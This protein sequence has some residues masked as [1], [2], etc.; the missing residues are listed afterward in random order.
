VTWDALA[1][2][3]LPSLGELVRHGVLPQGTL[4]TAVDPEGQFI[5]EIAGDGQ[6]TVGEF[7]YSSP[8]RAARE[9]GSDAGDGWTY[10]LA[11]INT[12]PV[13]PADLREKAAVG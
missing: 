3:I 2:R 4:V 10:W 7:T 5:G 1:E 8:G 13:T 9:H 6:L 12:E 11:H